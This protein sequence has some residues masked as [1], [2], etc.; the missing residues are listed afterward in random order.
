LETVSRRVPRVA[1]EVTCPGHCAQVAK[2]VI[3][4]VISV[5]RVALEVTCRGQLN[6]LFNRGVIGCRFFVFVFVLCGAFF[7]VC[8]HSTR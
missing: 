2:Y 1:L 5:P 6:L 4:E 7:F 3:V 8:G